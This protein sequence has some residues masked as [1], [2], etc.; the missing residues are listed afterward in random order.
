M[1]FKKWA[2]TFQHFGY[3]MKFPLFNDVDD[4]LPWNRSY[5]LYWLFRILPTSQPFHT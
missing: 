2:L 1:I 4:S 5:Q 3:S